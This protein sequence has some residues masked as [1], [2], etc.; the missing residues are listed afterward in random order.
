MATP[1]DLAR[2]ALFEGLRRRQLVRLAAIASSFQ[3][4]RGRV[5]FHQGEPAEGFYGIRSGRVKLYRLSSGGRQQVLHFFGAGDVFGEAAVFTGSTF[6]AFAQALADSRLIYIPKEPFVEALAGDPQLALNMLA[7]IS[8]YLR[9][10]VGLVEELAL[11]DVPMRLAR[12][13]L[14]LAGGE[15][16]ADARE[17]LEVRL[18]VSKTELAAHL[19]TVSETLSR[20][21]GRLRDLGLVEVRGRTILIA[22]PAGLRRL[23]Q[24]SR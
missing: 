8:R 3:V 15:A 10:F 4:R 6:P 18:P 19:G 9:R 20:T 16:S 7:T 13:L 21:L 17:P 23:A 1:E 2:L 5:I 22:D 14:D 11:R 24:S 12:Y